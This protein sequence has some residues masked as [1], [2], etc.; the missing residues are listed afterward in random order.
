MAPAGFSRR[1]MSGRHAHCS[2]TRAAGGDKSQPGIRHAINARNL[3]ENTRRMASAA[4][5]VNSTRDG[6]RPAGE[7]GGFAGEHRT[8]ARRRGS[9][10]LDTAAS[11]PPRSGQARLMRSLGIEKSSLDVDQSSSPPARRVPLAVVRVSRV[12]GI[13]S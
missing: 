4:N 1:G 12:A 8:A 6:G 10:F 11:G 13:C 7:Y 3:G 5:I 9:P 2:I